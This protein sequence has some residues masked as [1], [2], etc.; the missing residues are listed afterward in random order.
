[1][2]QSNSYSK[3]GKLIIKWI[4]RG[5]SILAIFF[6]IKKISEMKIDYK[7]ILSPK[8]IALIT[9]LI[10]VQTALIFVACRAWEHYLAEFG[11][12]EINQSKVWFIYSKANLF[13]YI[14]GNVFQYVGRNELAVSTNL[15]HKQVAT[16]TLADTL[17]MIFIKL[18]VSF[19]LLRE[20]LIRV[21]EK[22]VK[23]E[24][25]LLL[26]Y[27]SV[28]TFFIALVVLLYKKNYLKILF[29]SRKSIVKCLV[30]FLI[31]DIVTGFMYI[32]IISVVLDYNCTILQVLLL[33]GGYTLASV[34]GFLTPGAPGGIGIREAVILFLSNDIIDS[35]LLTTAVVTMRIICIAADVF[36]FG[37]SYMRKK[38][39]DKKDD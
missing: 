9:V 33:I 6:I 7:L 13:K 21:I 27:F 38:V 3:F 24:I 4:G 2:S 10:L 32:V 17:T 39:N 36:A 14:P 29:K 28:V 20:Q 35:N 19:I 12:K 25:L 16:A 23:R 26:F 34:I 30:D 11:K 31:V 8:G 1:M 22:Y 5:L 37:F 15:T 18:V